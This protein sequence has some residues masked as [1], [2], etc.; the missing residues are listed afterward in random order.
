MKPDLETS[1]YQVDV[2]SSKA[3]DCIRPIPCFEIHKQ[4]IKKRKRRIFP[5]RSR[6]KLSFTCRLI[7]SLARIMNAVLFMC[8]ACFMCIYSSLIYLCTYSELF[9]SWHFPGILIFK[10]CIFH[11]ARICTQI[12][13][14]IVKGWPEQCYANGHLVTMEYTSIKQALSFGTQSEVEVCVCMCVMAVTFHAAYV[15]VKG[16]TWASIHLVW[17]NLLP[18]HMS[19]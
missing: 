5:W 7:W 1:T 6:E 10:I 16:Q 15:E 19:D 8:P 12:Q 2:S 14:I 18:L 9:C 11:H 13:I 3:N 17:D 4:A